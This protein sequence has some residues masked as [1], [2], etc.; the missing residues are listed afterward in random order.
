MEM[1]MSLKLALKN[2]ISFWAKD[3][4]LTTSQIE[5]IER[6]L[7]EADQTYNIDWHVTECTLWGD[8][9][10]DG[11]FLIVTNDDYLR[12]DVRYDL[13]R[14]NDYCN[15]CVYNLDEDLEDEDMKKDFQFLS[16]TRSD[17]EILNWTDYTLNK[18]TCEE[19]VWSF[20]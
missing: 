7:T 5:K 19:A 11:R 9:S 15:R 13:S 8:F 10:K 2:F 18:T 17:E 12:L 1:T 16:Q 20:K 3:Y 4:P 6:L 14:Q